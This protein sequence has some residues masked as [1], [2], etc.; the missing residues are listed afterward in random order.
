MTKSRRTYHYGKLKK[1][2]ADIVQR[3]NNGEPVAKVADEFK[4]PPHTIHDMVA[5]ARKDDGEPTLRERGRKARQREL[6]KRAKQVTAL[7]GTMSQ[8]EIGAKLGLSTHQVAEACRAAGIAK[9]GWNGSNKGN[10]LV[11][12]LCTI[13][14]EL[15]LL[16]DDEQRLAAVA[17]DPEQKTRAQKALALMRAAVRTIGIG[18]RGEHHGNGKAVSQ[19]GAPGRNHRLVDGK[20]SEE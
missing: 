3:V 13:V 12:S 2:R 7:Y 10:P 8:V 19:V 9:R 11:T 6:A 18:L 14:G 20:T 16:A 5:K 15:E 1:H 4:V 17:N